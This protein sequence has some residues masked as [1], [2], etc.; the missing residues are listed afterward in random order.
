MVGEKKHGRLRGSKGREERRRIRPTTGNS[1][2]CAC[3]ALLVLSSSSFRLAPYVATVAAS[4]TYTQTSM[5]EIP[6][7]ETVDEAV[8]EIPKEESGRVPGDPV[9]GSGPRRKQQQHRHHQQEGRCHWGSSGCHPPSSPSSGG[10]AEEGNGTDPVAGPFVAP[11][12]NKSRHAVEAE[13]LARAADA[14]RAHAEAAAMEADRDLGLRDGIGEGGSNDDEEFEDEEIDQD[15]DE[16][17]DGL[18]TA[19]KS[20]SSPNGGVDASRSSS[21]VLLPPDGFILAARIISDPEDGL[22]YFTDAPPPGR[23]TTGGSAEE[24]SSTTAAA[25]AAAVNLLIPYLDCGA[26]GSL[27]ADVSP[28]DGSFHHFPHGSDP[29]GWTYAPEPQLI[30]ALSPMEITVSGNG[31]ETRTFRTGDVVYVEEETSVTGS[32]GGHKVKAAGIAMGS[33][34][35]GHGHGQK[36]DLSVLVVTLHRRKSS[37][38]KLGKLFPR[39]FGRDGGSRQGLMDALGLPAPQEDGKSPRPC[40]TELDPSYASGG[41]RGAISV[42]ASI[43][44][45]SQILRFA[46]GAAVSA[47]VILS[48]V[49]DVPIRSVA[50]LGGVC[51]AGGTT[52]LIVK[53][54]ERIWD[55]VEEWIERRDADQ[56]WSGE[57]AVEE[58]AKEEETSIDSSEN[59]GLGQG[60][61]KEAEEGPR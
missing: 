37:S 22:S 9:D 57:V 26:V 32:K 19:R 60:A 21:P 47:A 3:A 27:T 42:L 4:K 56:R 38:R 24:D 18:A 36:Q 45:A 40:R 12:A 48:L 23:M 13:K 6:S 2:A 54:G 28:K 41:A 1:T 25:E 29:V 15:D 5:S 58:K 8:G 44:P 35:S 34:G 10:E 33:S 61:E 49:R 16:D 11:S 50:A 7:E 14:A 17:E 52:T 46:A 39:I 20:S 55:A 43:P 31:G 53:G 51:L 59:E 30:A